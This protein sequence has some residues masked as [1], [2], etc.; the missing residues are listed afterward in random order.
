MDVSVAVAAVA[1]VV[2]L[3]DGLTVAGALAGAVGEEAAVVGATFSPGE[4]NAEGWMPNA[5]D[6]AHCSRLGA[7]GGMP[8]FLTATGALA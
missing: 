5:V 2:A 3:L 1:G 8:G 6:G 7:V 4:G